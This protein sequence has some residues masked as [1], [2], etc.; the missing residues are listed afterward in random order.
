M[1]AGNELAAID[2]AGTARL[3][4]AMVPTMS[5]V[6]LRIRRITQHLQSL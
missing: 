1:A 2:C 3:A 5:V 6:T 4:S